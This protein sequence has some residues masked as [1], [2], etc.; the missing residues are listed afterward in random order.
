M[1]DRDSDGP[2]KVVFQHYV[3]EDDFLIILFLLGRRIVD[4]ETVSAF[5]TLAKISEHVSGF[6]N[7]TSWTTA[8][9]MKKKELLYVFLEKQFPAVAPWNSMGFIFQC[10]D[11]VLR[12]AQL[13]SLVTECVNEYES[14]IEEI[15]CFR[16]LE[17]D[18]VV[19]NVVKEEMSRHATVKRPQ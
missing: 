8:S 9:S 1:E 7:T 5:A 11:R 19:C 2:M 17:F 6:M 16:M 3:H 18:R 4:V 13:H 14:I 15:K 12:D 10:G